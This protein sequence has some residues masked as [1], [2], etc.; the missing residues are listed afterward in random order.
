M[1]QL[2]HQHL[3]ED[4]VFIL[5]FSVYLAVQHSSLFCDNLLIP[6]KDIHDTF[7]FPGYIRLIVINSCMNSIT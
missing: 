3:L 6:H 1:I 4:T 7:N 2:Q 5:M